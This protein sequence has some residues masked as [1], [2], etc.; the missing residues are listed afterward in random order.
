[1][2]RLLSGRPVLSRHGS[3]PGLASAA[4]ALSTAAASGQTGLPPGCPPP[5]LLEVVRFRHRSPRR[6]GAGRPM[7]ELTLAAIESVETT[8]LRLNAA[9]GAVSAGSSIPSFCSRS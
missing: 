9:A 3:L 8:F 6:G 4:L 1:M 5:A 2:M 7:R